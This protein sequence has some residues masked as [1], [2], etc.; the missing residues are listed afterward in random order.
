[1]SK[2]HSLIWQAHLEKNAIFLTIEM[3]RLFAAS[4]E[5]L[6]YNH[7]VAFSKAFNSKHFG[8]NKVVLIEY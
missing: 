6:P 3:H 4:G 2:T 1:M 8:W 7:R 5:I